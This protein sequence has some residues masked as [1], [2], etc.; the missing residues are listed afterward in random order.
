MSSYK[1][2]R[3]PGEVMISDSKDRVS[4]GIVQEYEVASDTSSAGNG[5]GSADP[6][7]GE[8]G[9]E[10]AAPAVSAGAAEAD[11]TESS[12]DVAA[13]NESIVAEPAESAETSDVDRTDGGSL[14]PE[15]APRG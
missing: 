1:R 10:D 14:V 15:I 4:R 3:I 9:A 5:V 7:T 6:V 12:R 2:Q 11:T 8:T 13:G